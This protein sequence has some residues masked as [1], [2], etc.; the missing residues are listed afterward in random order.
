MAF[1]VKKGRLEIIKENE[2]TV[3]M[4]SGKMS[5]RL[6]G[7]CLENEWKKG[8]VNIIV[9]KYEKTLVRGKIRGALS[10]KMSERL[11]KG[12]GNMKANSFFVQLQGCDHIA[13]SN[14]AWF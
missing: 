2:R 3:S 4:V 8:S 5:G 13:E 7:K 14:S 12:S 9:K 1:G 11:K 6:S 10:G